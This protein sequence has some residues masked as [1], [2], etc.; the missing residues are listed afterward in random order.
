MLYIALNTYSYN[1]IK[2]LLM[3]MQKKNK[4]GSKFQMSAIVTKKIEKKQDKSKIIH[5][6]K[7]TVSYVDNVIIRE[8][9]DIVKEQR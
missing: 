8:E 7:K 4:D 6:Q 2:H 1:K 5:K 3:G 9:G